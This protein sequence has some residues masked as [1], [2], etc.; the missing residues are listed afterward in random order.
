MK[1][2][3][4]IARKDITET[5]RM[6]STYFTMLFILAIFSPYYFGLMSIVRNVKPAG[7]GLEPLIRLYI[8]GI[9]M[10]VPLT[11]AALVAG[12][13][14]TYSMIMEKTK[15]GFESLLA[16]PVT[17]RQV[18]LGKSLAVFLPC[19]A[20]SVI[21]SLLLLTFLNFAVVV[22]AMDSFVIPDFLPVVTGLVIVP[23]MVFLLVS[24][25]SLLQLVLTNPRIPILVFSIVFLSLYFGNSFFGSLVAFVGAWGL[26]LFYLAGSGVL[27]VIT[28]FVSRYLTAER[29]I[30]SSKG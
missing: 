8:N 20:V 13:F 15:R 5:L 26:S 27:A 29:I 6:R 24:L 3:L 18:W 4:I 7:S 16:T 14:S 1:K 17:L 2:A 11:V 12:S 21:A 28:L 19:M 25:I 23:V 22:P 10:S 9:I 30:L